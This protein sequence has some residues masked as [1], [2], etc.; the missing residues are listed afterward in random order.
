MGGDSDQ[1]GREAETQGAAK[2]ALSDGA[3]AKR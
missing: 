1:L 3:G 2:L